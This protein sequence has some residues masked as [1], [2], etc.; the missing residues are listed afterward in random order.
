MRKGFTTHAGLVVNTVLGLPRRSIVSRYLIAV[1]TFLLSGLYHAALTPN[2][3][4][5]CSIL[6]INHQMK[7]LGIIVLEDI[8]ATSWKKLTGPTS[9]NKDKHFQRQDISDAQTSALTSGSDVTQDSLRRRIEETETI[10]GNNVLAPTALAGD[11]T[12]KQ[13]N[14]YDN[15]D[16]IFLRMLGYL[17][18]ACVMIWLNSTLVF[19]TNKCVI[20]HTLSSRSYT[21][22][23][24][25]GFVQ[26]I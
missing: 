19:A 24:E 17:W 25:N 13:K 5:Q 4:W 12:S 26:S 6:Q 18:T 21:Y 20:D 9:L 8:V 7:V 11:N 15:R 3:P 14:H 1:V 16:L 22:F 23:D 10:N 2:I